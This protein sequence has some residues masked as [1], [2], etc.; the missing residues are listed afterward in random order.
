MIRCR[1]DEVEN[2]IRFLQGASAYLQEA[3]K[4]LNDLDHLTDKVSVCMRPEMYRM[5]FM[6]G[7]GLSFPEETYK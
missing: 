2:E 6:E 4:L 7:D 1:N 3:L 5:P